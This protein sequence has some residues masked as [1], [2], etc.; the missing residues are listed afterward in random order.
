M[1]RTGL[2]GRSI[3]ASRSPWLHEQEAKAQGLDLSYELFDFTAL[4]LAD[5]ELGPLLRRLADDG[6]S[7]VNITYPFKQAVIPLLDELE[8]GARSVGAVNTVA[9]QEGRLIGYNTDKTGFQESLAEGL[10]DAE[11]DVVL[12]L[13][14]GGA[15]AAVA[16]ALLSLGTARLEISDVDLSRAETL[17]ERLCGEYGA[18]RVLARAS[19]DLDTALVQGIVN[20][21]P[22]GMSAHPEP[23][24]DPAKIAP[25]H[26]VADIVYFP[27]ETELLRLARAKGCRTLDGS[28]MVIGQAARAFQIFTGLTA[29]RKRMRTSFAA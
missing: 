13:G 15:G 19:G 22:M 25:H 11:L 1:K 27:I 8:D 14:A 9:M 12:Q 18:G 23:A 2:I 17:A 4:N 24:I 7:G 16:N 6:Y 5:G 26:W 20:T 10:P 28:G 3:Q 29:D 21:T